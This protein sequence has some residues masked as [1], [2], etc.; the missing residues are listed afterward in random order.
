MS[1][2]VSC[3]G[4]DDMSAGRPLHYEYIEEVLERAICMARGRTSGREMES[5]AFC[6][7]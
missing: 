5:D 6:P 4:I 3:K 7:T 1:G 2:L